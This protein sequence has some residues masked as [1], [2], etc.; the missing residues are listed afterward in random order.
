MYGN[1]RRGLTFSSFP[2]PAF[3]PLEKHTKPNVDDLFMGF[4]TRSQGC[5]YAQQDKNN[6]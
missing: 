4:S 6:K 3:P 5:H 2:M 1:T